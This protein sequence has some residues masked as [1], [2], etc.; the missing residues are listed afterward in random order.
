MLK[1]DLRR[2]VR[3]ERV[4][5]Q[6]SVPPDSERWEQGDTRPAGPLQVELEV[7]LAG[8]DVLARG[9]MRGTVELEC[10][11]CLDPVEVPIERDLALLYRSGVDT[12]EAEEQEV[13][14][15]PDQ[16]VELDLWE[17]VREQWFLNA[18]RYVEC[19][20]DCSGLCPRCGANLNRE[21]CDCDLTETDH[22]WAP[23]L[24]MKNE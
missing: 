9:S 11:R 22:R 4:D 1:V 20:A 18:P 13:Y 15:L 19:D 5:V 21:S 7:Q 17:A 3:G 6:A 24:E 8:V 16:G 2:L 10:R 23:L 12:E 14:P